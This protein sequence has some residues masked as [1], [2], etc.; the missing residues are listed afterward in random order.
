M[1]NVTVGDMN[2]L[3]DLF[4]KIM[5]YEKIMFKENVTIRISDLEHWITD[6]FNGDMEKIKSS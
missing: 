3:M 1:E 6:I 5:S 2:K 4:K